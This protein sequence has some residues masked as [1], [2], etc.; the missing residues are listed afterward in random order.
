MTDS[1]D[2]IAQKLRK[3]KSDAD[4]LPSEMN[5]LEGRAE[6][7]NLV[8]IY[9]ATA[10]I[11]PQAVLDQ[12]GGQGFG[13][14]KPALTE[15][16]VETLKPIRDRF[17]ELKA[18]SAAIDAMLVKGAAKATLMGKPTLDAAYEALGLSR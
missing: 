5:G 4:V 10:E 7:R 11:E 3:A 18:D 17:V 8:N 15:L 13:A 14:F 16:L 1:D 6:A 9:A 2:V 12:Y